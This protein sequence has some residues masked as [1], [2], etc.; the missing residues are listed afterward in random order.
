MRPASSFGKGLRLI[1][2]SR[3]VQMIL[4]GEFVVDAAFEDENMR[5]RT[6]VQRRSG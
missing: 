1:G 5:A 2:L 4:A 6:W 3:A